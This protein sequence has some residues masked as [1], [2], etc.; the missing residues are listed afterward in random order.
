MTWIDFG[1]YQPLVAALLLVVVFVF[2][3]REMLP[4][5]MTAFYGAAA[6]LTLGLVTPDDVLAAIANPA[7]ATIGAMFILSAALVR[8]GALEQLITGISRIAA[9]RPMHAVVLFFAAAAVA[10]AFMNNTPVVMVLIPVVLG[11]ARQIGSGPS[12]MLIPL[13]YMVIL[14]GTCTMIGTSTNLLV[15]GIARDLGLEPFSLFEIAPLGIVVALIGG[16]YLALLAPRLL[17]DRGPGVALVAG[18]ARSWLADLF[19]PANSPLIGQRPGEVAALTREG[20]R[21]VDVVRG[22]ASLRHSLPDV[23]L[24]AGD[25][26]VIRTRDV[27]VM[28]FR[29]GHASGV[30]VPG[31][32]AAQSRRSSVVEVLVGPTCRAFG[33]SLAELRWRRRFGVYAIALH[34][35]GGQVGER[36]EQTRLAVGDTLLLDGAPEDVARLS[37]EYGLI[38]LNPTA[39]RAFRRG[40]API[41]VGVLA[42]V[43]LLAALDVA[44]ILPLA[45]LGVA[46]VFAAGCIDAQEGFAAMDGRLLLLVISML[47]I[48][49]AVDRSG[50]LAIAIER[51]APMLASL[52]PLVALALVYA[53]AS[54]VT[55]LVTNNAVAVLLTPLAAGLA[56]SLGLDPRPFVVAV[57]FGASASFATPIG[58]QTNTLVYNAGGYRFTDFLRIGVPM[59]LIVGVVTVL[60]VPLVWPLQ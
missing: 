14:G 11:L 59:N 49:Q 33:R 55:E 9:R 7:P 2:F 35:E 52:H 32:E 17:P 10:S 50:A 58:Y 57:M 8:T 45:L 60:I 1:A 26:V 13:S 31:L 15:D 48:G 19:I 25:V 16:A 23:R 40:K 46:V 51:V 24:E 4:A 22:D 56:T 20:S 27:E 54:V 36:L 12:R 6:A 53:L 37:A 5:E 47:V 42:A 34:R 3:V 44:P 30:S 18:D 43:V 38:Q 28:G 21:I 29:E 39:A 41:A